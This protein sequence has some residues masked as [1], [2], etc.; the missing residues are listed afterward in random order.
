VRA[1]LVCLPVSLGG[2]LAGH[3]LAYEGTVGTSHGYMSLAEMLVCAVLAVGFVAAVRAPAGRAPAWLFATCPPLAFLLLESA[4]R[5]FDP[6]FLLEP[7]V[8]VGLVLQLPFAVLAFGLA[9]LLLRAADALGRLLR[10]RPVVRQG[11]R[12]PTPAVRDEPVG[13]FALA[14]AGRGPPAL[15]L[16]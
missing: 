13:L 9:R 12:L 5:A 10:R 16:S 6:A 3:E 4:E 14:G 15:S 11:V 7:A 8:L 1:L 2:M